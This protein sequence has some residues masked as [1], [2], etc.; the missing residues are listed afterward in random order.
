MG[1]QRPPPPSFL[2]AG[3]EAVQACGQHGGQPPST[4]PQVDSTVPEADPARDP[5]EVAW[6]HRESGP[7]QP[8]G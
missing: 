4:G 5:Q 1:E 2:A 7:A 6:G 3:S 8:R